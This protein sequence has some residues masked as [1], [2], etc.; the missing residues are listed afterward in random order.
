MELVIAY[1]DDSL[2]TAERARF[3]AHL[4]ECPHCVRYLEQMRITIAHVGFLADDAITPAAWQELLD[5]FRDWKRDR[6]QLAL[7]GVLRVNVEDQAHLQSPKFRSQI[8]DD[9]PQGVDRLDGA[10]SANEDRPAFARP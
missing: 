6:G 7:L 2:P 5:C 10:V 9:V 4:L 1:L 3:N 8:G